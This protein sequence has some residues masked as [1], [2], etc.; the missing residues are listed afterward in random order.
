M[1]PY[2]KLIF[3]IAMIVIGNFRTDAQSREDEPITLQKINEICHDTIPFVDIPLCRQPDLND[4]EIA[5]I[6]Q[7]MI[8]YI[9]MDTT[10]A[11]GMILHPLF[12]I[13]QKKPK[14]SIVWVV[15]SHPRNLYAAKDNMYLDDEDSEKIH[16]CCKIPVQSVIEK[17][18][19]IEQIRIEKSQHPFKGWTSDKI[20]SWLIFSPI[21]KMEDHYYVECNLYSRRR[22]EY[23]TFMEETYLFKW[24]SHPETGVLYPSWYRSMYCTIEPGAGSKPS[25][26]TYL[27]KDTS[28]FARKY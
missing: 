6:I 12:L 22:Y 25:P 15:S 9:I 24:V 23:S 14:D 20:E 3:S 21:L 28:P 16:E 13:S 18:E 19:F 27:Y 7:Q 11:Y 2:F 17:T 4:Y 26:R 10:Y 1:T 8:S 5:H